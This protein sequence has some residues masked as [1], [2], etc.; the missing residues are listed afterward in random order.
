MASRLISDLAT[1]PLGRKIGYL[2]VTLVAFGLDAMVIVPESGERQG[3]HWTAFGVWDTTVLQFLLA[4]AVVYSVLLLR[5]RWPMSVLVFISVMSLVL[6]E[7][8]TLSQPVAGV[9]VSLYS[10]ASTV[11]RRAQAWSALLIGIVALC[12]GVVLAIGIRNPDIEL[13]LLFLGGMT[14]SVWIFGRREHRASITELGLPSR[15]A[16]HGELAAAQERR[17][18]AHELHDI[19]AH[20]VSAMMMQAAGAKAMTTAH[21]QDMPP[22]APLETVERALATIENTG[23]QSMRELHRLLSV[24]R[25]DGPGGQTDAEFGTQPG[26]ADIAPLAELTRQSG[27]SVDVHVDGTPVK[28]DPSVGLA[29]YRVVQESLTNA[30]KHGGRGATVDV[31]QNWRP[32]RLRL[33]VRSR[34]GHDSTSIGSLGGGSGLHGL[35]ERV[36]LIGGSFQSGWVADEFVATAVL[37]LTPVGLTRPW[38]RLSVAGPAGRSTPELHGGR[39]RVRGTHLAGAVPVDSRDE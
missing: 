28:L 16:E 9:L 6:T 7:A 12:S 39:A 23:A 38:S 21:R 32:D 20:S 13:A 26:I 24:L 5:H 36:E 25:G 4:L 34:R 15:L 27:L 14:Y 33:Q 37:P 10:A 3:Q 19:L 29:A 17:R 31:F 22:N 11:D 18:I 8:S 35:R 2:L 30:M 1:V